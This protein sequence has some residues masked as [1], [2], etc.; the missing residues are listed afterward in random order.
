MVGLEQIKNHIKKLA[1]QLKYEQ[2]RHQ[3]DP[4]YT[5]RNNLQHM[6][7]VGNPGTGKTTVARLI[8]KIYL[9]LGLL[10]KGHCVEVGRSDLV[11]GYVGQTALKTVDK[12][13]EALDGILFIDEAY[14]LANQAGNDFGQE[15]IDTLVKLMEDYRERLVVI[16][17]G[18]PDKMGRFIASNP[19]LSSRFAT[20]MHFQDFSESELRAILIQLANQENYILDPNAVEMACDS[21]RIF[22]GKSPEHF[23]NARAVRN[24]FTQMKLKLANRIVQSNMHEIEI[25]KSMNW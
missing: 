9:C 23:G 12:V 10:R 17:A 19:G 3:I 24:F 20:P 21:L 2:L 13:K 14:S 16:V 5:P 4:T 6:I 8:G 11:A 25:S 15:A 1:Y 7:F 18:Y 22:K